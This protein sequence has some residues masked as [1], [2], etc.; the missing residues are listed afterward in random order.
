MLNLIK[1]ELD[2]VSAEIMSR[3]LDANPN[4]QAAIVEV[5]EKINGIVGAALIVL[6]TSKS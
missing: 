1:D 5:L 4:D 3:P 6:K 2:K